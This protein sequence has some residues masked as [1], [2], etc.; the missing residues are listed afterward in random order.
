MTARSIDLADLKDRTLKRAD[1]EGSGDRYVDQSDGGELDSLINLGVSEMHVLMMSI[2]ADWVV[3]QLP[4]TLTGSAFALP[5]DHW[6]TRGVDKVCPDGNV[7]PFRELRFVARGTQQFSNDQD[8]FFDENCIKWAVINDVLNFYPM[9]TQ[10]GNIR[11]SYIPTAP[12]LASSG[13]L[14]PRYLTINAWDE[15]IVLSTAAKIKVKKDED[16]TSLLQQKAQIE[17]SMVKWGG[18]DKTGQRRI[19]L[20]RTAGDDYLFNTRYPRMRP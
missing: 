14:L 12:L 3:T 2:N 7:Q 16:P 11:L 4:L 17:A 8:Q 13:S 9:T 10:P 15:F 6:E 5:D 18:R 1:I 20:I 19:Q